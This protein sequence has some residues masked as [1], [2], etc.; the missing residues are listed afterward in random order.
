MTR[1]RATLTGFTA[2]LMWALLALLT[3][4]SA[5]VPPFQLN[6]VCFAI[7]GG[8]GLLWAVSTG[9]IGVLR[10]VPWRVYAYG[11]AGLFGAH[12][13]YFTVFR[14]AEPAGAAAQA[15]LI[16]YLW[17]MLIV[18]LSGLLPGERLRRNH[19]IGATIAFAGAALIVLRPGGAMG[20][21][22]APALGLAFVFALT[23]ATYSVNARRFAEVPTVSVAV[24]CGAAAVLSVPMHLTFETT[25]WPDT[26]TGWLAVVGLG[27]GPVGLAFFTWDIGMKQGDIQLLGVAAYAAP[28]LS[29]LALMLA[30][31]APATPMLLVSALLIAGGAVIAAR[32]RG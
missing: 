17:P 7:S 11:T 21:G 27:L 28:L 18:L 16:A 5:P 26:A 6:A 3:V 23:W 31:I 8:L 25:A 4:L 9:R 2:I 15:G 12:A 1:A 19:L 30:G 20:S 24:I 22:A 14:L 10:G 29:T 13:I 32:A